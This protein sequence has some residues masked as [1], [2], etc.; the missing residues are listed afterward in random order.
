MGI[1]EAIMDSIKACSEETWPHF[2]SNIVLTGGNAK[3][4]GF[5]D[6]VY[7]EVRSLAPA[8]YFVNVYLPQKYYMCAICYFL[9]MKSLNLIEL[10]T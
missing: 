9:F 5:K 10:Y 8:K 4:P 2:L 3:F 7:K 1:P 6:R